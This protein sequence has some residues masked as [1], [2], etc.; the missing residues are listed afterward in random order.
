MATQA[1][2]KGV[3][4][5]T[6]VAMLTILTSFTTPFS[7]AD[8]PPNAPKTLIVDLLDYRVNATNWVATVN[9]SFELP[10]D[11]DPAWSFQLNGTPDRSVCPD[12][13]CYIDN[14]YEEST[15]GQRGGWAWLIVSTIGG[16]E[17]ASTER[18]EWGFRNLTLRAVTPD[19][20]SG[21][22]SCTIPMDFSRLDLGMYQ[23]PLGGTPGFDDGSFTTMTHRVPNEAGLPSYFACGSNMTME[24]PSGVAAVVN[25][26]YQTGSGLSDVNVTW[27]PTRNDTSFSLDYYVLRHYNNP[28]VPTT[29]LYWQLDS[30][31]DGLDTPTRHAKIM[32]GSGINRTTDPVWFRVLARDPLT[33]QQSAESCIVNVIQGRNNSAAACG[34]LD[35]T[36]GG[37]TISN[38]PLFPG[39]N[40]GLWSSEMGFSITIGSL[41]LSLIFAAVLGLLAWLHTNWVG[42]AVGALVG[43]AI[44]VSWGLFPIWIILAIFGCLVGIIVYRFSAGGGEA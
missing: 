1:A 35:F 33:H 29:T 7:Y 6:C 28:P 10:P 39:L 31:T 36:T 4:V 44:T 15:L 11:F 14:S 30:N 19:T 27:R 38:T 40:V 21:A 5:A 43:I 37:G 9:V 22:P 13:F 34:S 17:N 41:V 2:P 16:S 25:K 24:A 26:S 32:V 18:S 3:V 8:T 42:G 12:S 20:T 23:G